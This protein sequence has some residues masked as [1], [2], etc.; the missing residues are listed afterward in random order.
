MKDQVRIVS[1][2]ALSDS[3]ILSPC[4]G[5]REKLLDAARSI[6][7]LII[8]QALAIEAE[9]T[10]T[11]PVVDALRRT[12]LFWM[13]VPRDLGGSGVS[14]TDAIE[15]IEEISAADGSVGWSLMANSTS[16][17]I[18]ASFCG[19]GAMGPMFGGDEPAIVAGMF[20]PGGTSIETADGLIAGGRFTFG[21]GCAHA[22]WISAGMFVQEDG[23]PRLLVNGAP[24]VR[25]CFF[26][27]DRVRL[28]GNWDV[29]GLSGT[30]SY[31]YEIPEQFVDFDFTMER[32][33]V[34]P[35]RGGSVFSLGAGAFA[36]AGHGAV[37]LGLMQR[38]LSEVAALA[39]Q[40]K[41]PGYATVIGDHPVFRDAF[42]RWEA[43]YHATRGYF[44]K[45]FEDA[46]ETAARSETLSPEQRA[47]FRQSTTWLHE[48]AAELIRF[49]YTWSGSASIRANSILGRCLRDV[50]VA[51]QHVFVDRITLAD[52]A[53]TILTSWSKRTP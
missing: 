14:L 44:L 32:G 20:G 7:Q 9:G 34:D 47:R 15:I 17:A 27:I 31:D 51:T 16:T 24:E 28:A 13:L 41:R 33:M 10:L 43:Q 12:G 11:Q 23:I 22:T 35:L 39:M 29:I 30:G 19:D 40:K 52:A 1:N 8:D 49:C 6:R 53:P 26:P 45:V 3:K 38:A 4:H 37:V 18:A 42:S 2:T 50:S 48:V 46:Q 36:C 25:V 21:S 5:N